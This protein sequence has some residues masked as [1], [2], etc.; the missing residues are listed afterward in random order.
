MVRLSDGYHQMIMLSITHSIIYE[1][2]I[3]P[4]T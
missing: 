4:T 2:V 1:A 3:V